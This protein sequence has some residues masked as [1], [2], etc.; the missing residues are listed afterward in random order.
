[1]HLR[2]GACLTTYYLTG[3]W[4]AGARSGLRGP[5]RHALYCTQLLTGAGDGLAL[6]DVATCAPIRTIML[7]RGG[8]GGGG[9]A[10]GGHVT[11]ARFCPLNFNLALVRGE[12]T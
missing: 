9:G 2:S 12:R 6:W 4:L 11:A 5:S 8:G 3:G 10:G 7:S 1:M